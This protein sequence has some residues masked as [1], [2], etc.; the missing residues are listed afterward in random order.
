M[1]YSSDETVRFDGSVPLSGL[2]EPMNIVDSK[3]FLQ[4]LDIITSLQKS[5]QVLDM[6]CRIT[7]SSTVRVLLACVHVFVWSSQEPWS[8]FW[9]SLSFCVDVSAIEGK[10]LGR[11][12]SCAQ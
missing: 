5:F 8:I 10:I 11:D 7:R 9:K 1:W 4:T 2:L 12:A 6:S 3:I